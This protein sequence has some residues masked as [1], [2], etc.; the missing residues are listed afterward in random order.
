MSTTA[1]NQ[2][3][4]QIKTPAEMLEHW[5]GHRRLTRR[6]I[7]AFPADAFFTHS[8]GGMRPFVEMTMELMAI[9][10]P[11][12]REVV[13][14]EQQHLREHFD[15]ENNKDKMLELWDKQTEEINTFWSQITE[16]RF[17]ETMTLFGQFTFPLWAHIDYFID[18]EIHHRGQA[19][20][21]LRSLG[22]APPLFY[23]R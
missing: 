10:A 3:R 18:N 5:Q 4:P 15:H 7:E 1:K 8:I 13:T 2:L 22:I 12:L 14:G 17:R 20:V 19:Y 16:E 9:G 11:G 21:Y 23:E 6:V